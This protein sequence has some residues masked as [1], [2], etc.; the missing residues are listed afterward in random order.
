MI[1]VVA[2]V[3]EFDGKLLAFQRGPAKYEYVANKYE[4]P[5]G[6]VEKGEDHKIAL[7][8]ELREE[9]DVDAEVKEYIMTIEHASPISRSKCTV[10]SFIWITSSVD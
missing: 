8:R 10:L 9:L 7:A 5:G 4:F 1:E 6:K 3:I 2:A